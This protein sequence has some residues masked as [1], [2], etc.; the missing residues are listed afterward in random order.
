MLRMRADYY[1]NMRER[2]LQYVCIL[3]LITGADKI[4]ISLFALNRCISENIYH[5][6]ITVLKKKGSSRE[7]FLALI[8]QVHGAN[9]KFNFSTSAMEMST[10]ADWVL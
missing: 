6:I 9:V 10:G 7:P 3:L 8:R 1:L 2:L 5:N 4:K